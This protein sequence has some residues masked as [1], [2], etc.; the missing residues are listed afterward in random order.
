MKTSEDDDD[1]FP[2][3]NNNSNTASPVSS[4]RSAKKT[5]SKSRTKKTKKQ[6]I[7]YN[8]RS[9][10]Y[11]PTKKDKLEILGVFA[12]EKI[13]T[14]YDIYNLSTDIDIFEKYI[15]YDCEL[16]LENLIDEHNEHYQTNLQLHDIS[17]LALINV[18]TK[19]LCPECG[20]NG[21]ETVCDGECGFYY[22]SECLYYDK[23][24]EAYCESCYNSKQ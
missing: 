3:C 12:N 21:A 2:L 22:H 18:F 20:N 17:M 13:F 5:R 7:N 15:C 14:Q 4:P 1:Y 6:S 24:D 16:N 11:V 19:C 23:T 9:I 8:E 10:G